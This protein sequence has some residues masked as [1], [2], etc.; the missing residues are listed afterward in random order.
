MGHFNS[1]PFVLPLAYDLAT[2]QTIL[3]D[4]F[5]KSAM[6]GNEHRY[7][8]VMKLL[9]NSR[10]TTTKCKFNLSPRLFTNNL[11]LISDDCSLYPSILELAN[12][13]PISSMPI[14]SS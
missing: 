12:S 13:L 11:S 6:P 5:I 1:L 8:N 3:I 9:N 7:Q 14:Y 10:E 2:N 4:R